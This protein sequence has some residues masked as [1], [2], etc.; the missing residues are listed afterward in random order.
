MNS[1]S[2]VA[3]RV[4]YPIRK[5]FAE[6][7][8]QRYIPAGVFGLLVLLSQVLSAADTLL[9][10]VMVNTAASVSITAVAADSATPLFPAV[11]KQISA[12][13][14]DTLRLPYV[15][16]TPI[17]TSAGDHLRQGPDSQVS[18]GLVRVKFSSRFIG[19]PFQCFG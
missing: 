5:Y 12:G 10:P 9:L 3:K 18:P 17:V 11:T 14:T 7:F 2:S 16:G 1:N 13:S 6:F 8:S 15:N 19:L 4:V